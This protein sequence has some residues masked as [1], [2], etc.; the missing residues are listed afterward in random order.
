MIDDSRDRDMYI[1]YRIIIN[2]VFFLHSH[3]RQPRGVHQAPTLC[4]A[5]HGNVEHRGELID[6]RSMPPRLGGILIGQH[7]HGHIAWD[8]HFAVELDFDVVTHQISRLHF[9]ILASR[10]CQQRFHE[11]PPF[12]AACDFVKLVQQHMRAMTQI[13]QFCARPARVSAG[14]SASIP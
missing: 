2:I 9:R 5:K 1:Q 13:A 4:D 10:Q 3:S 11:I 7:Y 12:R 14:D 6:H 8:D